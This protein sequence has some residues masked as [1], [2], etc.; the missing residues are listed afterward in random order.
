MAL[1]SLREIRVAFGGPPLLEGASLQI[2]P[3]E[4]ICL[5]G[6]NGT[7]KSTL[8][9]VVN[10]EI[11][12]DEGEIV[13]QQG[14]K[15]AL[16]PQEVPPGLS[17]T[18][19]DVVSGGTRVAAEKAISRL[20]LPP[21]ADFGTLSGGM[22]RRVLIAR[23]LAR[24]S[25]VLLLDEPTNHLDI[26]GIAWL[27]NF[28]LREARTLFFVTHD[29]MFL[30]KTATRIVELD[31]GRLR[32]WACDYDTYLER[33]DADLAAETAQRARFDKRLAEEET[34]IRRGVKARGTRNEGRVRALERMREE[35]RAR[36][37]RVGT[38]RV[39]A[40][41][42]VSSGRLAVEVLG[43][44][45][46]YGDRPVIRDFSTTILRGDRVGIIGPNGSGKTTLLRVLLG[47]LSPRIGTVRLGTR[48]TVAY[49]DQLREGLDEEKTVA[50]NLG[51]GSDTVTV[52]GRPRHVIGY[53]QDVLFS[54]DRA[55]SPVRVL[56]GGERNRL[57]LAKLFTK[58]FNL[59]VLDEPTNDLDI[60]TLDLLEDL[61]MEYTGTL[62]LVSHDRAFLNNVVTSTLVIGADGTVV[63]YAG[64]Y[65][66]WLKQ[67]GE[68][69]PAETP[70][71]A[72]EAPR[73]KRE[74]PRK[75]GF[76]ER[77]ELT[78]LPGRIRDAEKKVAVLEAE[79]DELHCAM[80]DPAFYR[81]DG[82][83]IAQGRARLDAV[84][85]GIEEAYRRWESLEAAL[86]ELEAIEAK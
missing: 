60:E 37:E 20:G 59:L 86:A 25:D 55:M 70:P 18:V 13:R 19:Y 58:P 85:T 32:D 52:N 41:R 3:G 44:E 24:D 73:P 78:E 1:L 76:R 54:P 53:L 49:S 81:Q 12:P 8:L 11:A 31:R 26:E 17:G 62:L 14:V 45:V 23:A 64:G 74:G 39:Q 66:D 5:L 40:Q 47:E 21:G 65:D 9:R 72:R 68:T 29:R 38:V 77:R 79:R 43:V 10:G 27:E 46:G 35:R 82:E 84:Q 28:L 69:A 75:L 22:Q 50:E 33:R 42:V 80:A 7:G 36:R 57:Q 51:D 67:R 34:W 2:E 15:V 16:V 6:R 4:R 71:S 83:R 61:L 30:R 48:L 63:E 56:S